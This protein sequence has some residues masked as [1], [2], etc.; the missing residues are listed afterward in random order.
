MNEV[1]GVKE[2]T[3]NQISYI[4]TSTRFE[5]GDMIVIDNGKGQF[6]Y[7]CVRTLERYN[8]FS[9]KILEAKSIR[10]A[11]SSEILSYIENQQQKEPFKQVFIAMTKSLAINALLI[12]VE[13]S[14]END[15][16]KYT[17]FSIDK[18][19]FPKMIK[20][21]LMNNPRR[22]KIEFYQVGERE[23]YAING[24]LGVCGY[25]L[26]CHNRSFNTPTITT[27]A[28]KDIG[29]NI[30]LK[31]TLTGS[32]GK[33]KCCLLFEPAKVDALKRELPDLDTVFIYR[34]MPML[35]IDINLE[36]QIV[37]ASGTEIIEIEFDYFTKGNNVSNE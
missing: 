23:Y 4:F 27:S 9:H 17:Y 22:M 15:H 28:L 1:I 7:E 36:R 37:I 11:N 3:T 29:I 26:C 30:A 8:K 24:G 16:I 14:L 25:E 19:Q 5:V 20:Y 35:V 18:L 13:F 32:C 6:I 34:G 2:A 10:K 21:L 33:Y 31:K 12:D